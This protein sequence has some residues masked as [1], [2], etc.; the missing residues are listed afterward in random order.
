M[1]SPTAACFV[2]T[3][4]I[5]FSR[6]CV[7][8]ATLSPSADGSIFGR[9]FSPSDGTV[10]VAGVASGAGAAGVLGAAF[11][12]GAGG[13]GGVGAGAWANIA[14]PSRPIETRLRSISVPSILSLAVSDGLR[15]VLGCPSRYGYRSPG[16][17]FLDHFVGF[18]NDRTDRHSEQLC[19][20]DPLTVAQ[21]GGRT[22]A[23]HTESVV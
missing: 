9:C 19:F 10:G 17:G 20:L 2:L 14:L 1:R 3:L 12:L 15:K 4:L 16:P 8:G 7:P 23:H 22:C 13:V 6:I 18:S 5:M 21:V 11:T